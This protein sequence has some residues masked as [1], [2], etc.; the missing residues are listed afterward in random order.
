AEQV[1]GLDYS[2]HALTWGYAGATEQDLAI[3]FVQGDASSTGFPDGSFDLVAA[4]LLLH[5]QPP[6]ARHKTLKEVFRLLAPEGHL[7]L[8]DIPPYS[9]MEPEEAFL[10]DFDTW[11][12]GEFF[13]RGF[14]SENL[15]ELLKKAGF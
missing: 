13:W 14:L 5:E 8:L 10:Q 3:D 15:P 2:A 9:A 4:Y 11:G 6:A 1:V 12:N 7:L